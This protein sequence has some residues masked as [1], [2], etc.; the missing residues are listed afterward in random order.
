MKVLAVLWTHIKLS[1]R[2]VDVSG[3]RGV[4]HSREGDGRVEE[5][6]LEVLTGPFRCGYQRLWYTDEGDGLAVYGGRLQSLSR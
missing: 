5:T 1:L 6:L 3:S 4:G 2:D